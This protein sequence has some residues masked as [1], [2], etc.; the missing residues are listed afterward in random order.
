M[1]A[2]FIFDECCIKIIEISQD[3]QKLLQNIYSHV[4]WTTVLVL[5]W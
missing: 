5:L 3:L 2:E 1:V 4:L